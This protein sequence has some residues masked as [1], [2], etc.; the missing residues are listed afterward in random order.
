MGK[1]PTWKQVA[2][3]V[4]GWPEISVYT[5]G[6]REMEEW[7]AIPINLL[8]DRTKLLGSHMTTEWTNRRQEHEFVG[9]WKGVY[10]AGLGKNIRV[11]WAGNRCVKE[12]G[13]VCEF[14]SAFLT[15]K[16]EA[17]CSSETSV[18]FQWSTCRYIS[19][20]RTLHNHRCENLKSYV[21]YS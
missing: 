12:R 1:I 17:I 10:F 4:I 19:E 21:T 20:D 5:G 3:R 13:Q 6:Q 9:L 11:C 14:C 18:D 15:L 8:W 2:N 16:M 7:T